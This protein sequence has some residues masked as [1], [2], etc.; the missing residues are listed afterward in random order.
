[1]SLYNPEGTPPVMSN[2]VARIERRLPYPGEVLV[3]V[4]QRVGAD[5]VL[6]RAYIPSPPHIVNVAQLLAIP[7]AQIVRVLRHQ[8]GNR[9]RA[10]EPLVQARSAFV[11]GSRTPVD[12]VVSAIDP[13]TGY[14]T[15]TPDPVEFQLTATA[16][17]FV[18]D[19]QPFR[20]VTL[21]TPATQI[22]G[23]F[24]FGMERSGVLRLMVTDPT[25]PITADMIDPR[26]AYAILIGGAGISAEALRKAVAEQVR[27][28]IVGSVH[29]REVRNFLGMPHRTSWQTGIRS[30]QLP[31]RRQTDDPG[32]SLVVTEGFGAVAMSAPLFD[33][34]SSKDR[35]EAL[36]EGDT[37]LRN[38]HRRPRLILPLRR[39]STASNDLA[40]PEVRAGVTVRLLDMAH[41]GQIGI[42][43]TVSTLPRRL[44]SGVQAMAVEVVQNDQPSFWVPRTS[45]EV[46]A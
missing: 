11:R 21:E 41:L 15:I 16:P 6:A 30:W 13:N 39:S 45:V 32:L 29:E 2:T 19:V 26:S 37:S 8:V 33:L 9:V 10:N 44:D 24:G 12:G 38:R 3:R 42:V 40:Y 31:G 34:L 14:V 17:G 35:Q 5:E 7:P 23:V 25:E 27:G 18:M 1:M 43:R 20:G 28:I 36:I 22:Y 46:L 4:G